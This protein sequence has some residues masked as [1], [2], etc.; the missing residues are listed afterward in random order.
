MAGADVLVAA[1]NWTCAYLV[2]GDNHWNQ[3]PSAEMSL[4]T[5][6]EEVGNDSGPVLLSW[7][8]E[9][10]TLLNRIGKR[11]SQRKR[12]KGLRKVAYH[13]QLTTRKHLWLYRSTF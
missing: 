4:L 10:D 13:S 5:A 8:N 7:K 2:Q 6:R 9:L 12:R 3:Q 1:R 11:Y